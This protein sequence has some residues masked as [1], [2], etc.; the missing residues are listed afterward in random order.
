M[1]NGQWPRFMDL[2]ECDRMQFMQELRDI[3]LTTHE[4]WV[5]LDDFNLIYRAS[6]KSSG[7][8]NRR[9]M[10]QF[11]QPLEEIKMKE[12]HLHDC[13]FTW[14]TGTWAPTQIK[15]DHVFVTQD[16]ELLYEHCHL[17]AGGKSMPQIIA[18]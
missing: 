13:C 3:W 12:L 14:T 5:L 16:W 9:L 1:K 10:N 6:D 8:V 2:R 18:L 15:I 7:N 4:R 17:Q 11:H